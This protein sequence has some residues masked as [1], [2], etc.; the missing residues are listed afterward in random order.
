MIYLSGDVAQVW[1]A[2]PP[3]IVRVWWLLRSPPDNAKLRRHSRFT[4]LTRLDSLARL[5]PPPPQ[6]VPKQPRLVPPYPI[7]F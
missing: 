4:A 6:L 1:I 7:Y 3:K 5:V 2:L